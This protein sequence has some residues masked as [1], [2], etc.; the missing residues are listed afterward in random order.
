MVSFPVNLPLKNLV[1]FQKIDEFT[2]DHPIE[3]TITTVALAALV[4]ISFSVI[5]VV[6]TRVSIIL[7]AK[8]CLLSKFIYHNQDAFS[9]AIDRIKQKLK[10]W[11]EERN[12]DHT[13]SDATI[14][15]I[16]SIV[17]APLRLIPQKNEAILR[18]ASPGIHLIVS[19]I[20]NFGL[21]PYLSSLE[22]SAD[23]K[24]IEDTVESS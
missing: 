8:I 20:V 4:I 19:P 9:D 11:A 14:S 12:E 3:A 23:A 1:T 18:G 15:Y 17:A 22:T 10:A 7:V 21:L 24:Q 16:I 6:G 2:H 13:K 5:P